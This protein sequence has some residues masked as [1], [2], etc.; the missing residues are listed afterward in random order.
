LARP[1]QTVHVISF[2][3]RPF[4]G[5][6]QREILPFGQREI[7]PLPVSLICYA[8]LAEP[9]QNTNMNVQRRQPMF[10]SRSPNKG[11]PTPE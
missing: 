4:L 8:E 1:P 2:P 6:G 10:R 3:I 7:L 11:W 9:D 5:G